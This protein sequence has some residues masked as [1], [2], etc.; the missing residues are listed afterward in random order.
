MVLLVPHFSILTKNFKGL[1]GKKTV[2]LSLGIKQ[3]KKKNRFT[4]IQRPE[5]H[6]GWDLWL[7]PISNYTAL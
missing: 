4:I 7:R 6:K 1:Y 3:I 2:K 5:Y